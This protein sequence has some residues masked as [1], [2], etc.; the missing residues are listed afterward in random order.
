MRLRRALAFAGAVGAAAFTACKEP[1]FFPRWDSDMYMPLSSEPVRLDS[2]FPPGI[3]IPPG[4]SAPNGFTTQQD[5]SGVLK[6]VL[7][8]LV[9]DPTR[10]TSP[11]NSALSCDLLKLTLAKTLK[12][13]VQDTLFVADAQ[14]GLN[15]STPSTIVFPIVMAT[16]DLTRTDSVYLTQQSVSMLQAAGQ[17]GTTLW[18]ALRGKVSNPTDTVTVTSSDSIAVTTS[19]TVRIATVHQ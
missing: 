15:A 18:I 19:V 13:A 7:K 3:P 2:V 16:T 9:T 11:V 10:C 14:A 12:I 17:N 4:F 1:P 5:L 8:N 6:D